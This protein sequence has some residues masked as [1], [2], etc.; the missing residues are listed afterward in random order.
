MVDTNGHNGGDDLDRRIAEAQVQHQ[1]GISPAEGRAE[2]RGWA[3][4]IEFVGTVLV[5]GF[6][7]WGIDHWA[8]LGTAPWA[9]IVML[10]LGFIAG[11]RRAAQTS[12]QFD[13]DAGNDT[14]GKPGA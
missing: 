3:I 6:I 14:P 12:A 2:T 1:R 8:G 4:G 11:V 10:M 5:S 13:G 9:M 7:G